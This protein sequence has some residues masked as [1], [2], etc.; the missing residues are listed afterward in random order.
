MPYIGTNLILAG[1]RIANLTTQL[2]KSYQFIN[3]EL[4]GIDLTDP[5]HDG[6][7]ALV[8]NQPDLRVSLSQKQAVLRTIITTLKRSG[9]TFCTLKELATHA[10]Q[11]LQES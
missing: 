6:V 8:S 3:L 4:H 10:R 1:P 2:M 11:Q 5:D 9:Y 7:E